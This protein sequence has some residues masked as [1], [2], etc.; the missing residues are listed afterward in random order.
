MKLMFRVL[1]WALLV[2]LAVAIYAG[3]RVG[4]GHPFTIN[5]L[6]DRQAVA[7]VAR[8]PE[9]FTQIGLIDGTILDTHS[10]KLAPVGIAKRDADYAFA[11]KALRE[12]RLFDRAKLS[13]QDQITF[14]IL[15]DQYESALAFKPFAWVSSEGVFPVNQMWGTNVTLPSFMLSS[16]TIKNP[17]TAENFVRRME[18]MGEKIDG[19]TGEMQRQAQAGVI[20]PISIVERTLQITHDTIAPEPADNPMAQADRKRRLSS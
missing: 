2:A 9:L 16:H 11:E 1:G 6:A 14:D 17:K 13:V 8:N 10:G 7:F 3:Y 20:L 15:E 18:A 19:L 5:Q 4:F 12:V